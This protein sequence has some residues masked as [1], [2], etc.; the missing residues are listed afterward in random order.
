MVNLVNMLREHWVNVLV[1]LGFVIGIYMDR[2]NDEKLTA[3]RNKSMLY[4]RELKPG[5]VT[6]K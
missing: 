3:F 5:E 1:P 6:W 2:R 4:K